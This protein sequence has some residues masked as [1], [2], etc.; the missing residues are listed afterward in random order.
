MNSLLNEC[1]KVWVVRYEWMRMNWN[2]TMRWWS[3]EWRCIKLTLNCETKVDD[4][5]LL[6]ISI[7]IATRKVANWNFLSTSKPLSR[8]WNTENNKYAII[9]VWVI[10]PTV[11]AT[12]QLYQLFFIIITG[13]LSASWWSNWYRLLIALLPPRVS[14]S[15]SLQHR[16]LIKSQ[17]KCGAIKMNIKFIL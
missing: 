1:G 7:F 10:L 3:G 11:I 17:R 14:L 9:Y 4:C 12:T 16:C 5:Y 2:A 15:K 8:G 6:Q 13:S